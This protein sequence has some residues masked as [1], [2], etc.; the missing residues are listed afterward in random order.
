MA[1]GVYG[2]SVARDPTD[3]R[4]PHIREW[5]ESSFQD[6]RRTEVNRE[7]TG[8]GRL[9]SEEG[10]AS[11]RNEDRRDAG[12]CGVAANASDRNHA[13]RYASVDPT[14]ASR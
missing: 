13:R 1:Q 4:R 8:S 12:D 14:H 3:L 2:Q 7:R 9:G 11:Q 5:R 6:P 10:H